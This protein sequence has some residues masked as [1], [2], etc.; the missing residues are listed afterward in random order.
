MKTKILPCAQT[1]DG[2]EAITN[3]ITDA[4]AA[5][6]GVYVVDETGN[7]LDLICDL[8]SREAASRFEHGTAVPK[9]LEQ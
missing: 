6:F 5:F 1:S 9:Q 8:E 7:C 4:E 2:E 3:G